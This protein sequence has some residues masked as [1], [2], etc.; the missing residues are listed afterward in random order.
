MPRELDYMKDWEHMMYFAIELIIQ[1]K[2]HK[3]TGIWGERIIIHHLDHAN[4]LLM[5]SFLIKNGYIINYLEPKKLAK[6]TKNE[7]FLDKSKSMEYIDCLRLIC[8]NIL[9]PNSFDSEKQKK[10]ERFHNLRNEIQH[11]A[12]NINQDKKTEI[13]LFYPYFKEF[14]NLMFP[15]YADVFPDYQED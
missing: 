13:E 9:S 3:G 10:V 4:E 6:G 15:E 5:K 12:I 14:Y 8:N 2:L 11:R 1:S 7:E